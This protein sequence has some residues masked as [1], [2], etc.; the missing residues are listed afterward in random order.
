[1]KDV[2]SKRRRVEEFKTITLN[3]SC[4]AILLRRLPIKR[5]DPG[6]FKIAIEIGNQ[7]A[8]GAL[9]D[10]GASINL[11]PLSLYKK[12]KM[13]GLKPTTISMQLAD[14][15]IG[16]PDGIVE[17]VLVKVG[18]LI[19]PADFVIM[20]FDAD[21]AMPIILGRPFLATARTLIDVAEGELILRMGDE[22]V[23]FTMGK[24]FKHQ[25]EVENCFYLDVVQVN[26]K[27]PQDE[28][29]SDDDLEEAF[30]LLEMGRVDDALDSLKGS[31]SPPPELV[32]EFEDFGLARMMGDQLEKAFAEESSSLGTQVIATKEELK[33]RKRRRRR[34]KASPSNSYSLHY[35]NP[36]VISDILPCGTV[37]LR[38]VYNGRL[39]MVDRAEL[40]HYRVHKYVPKK[41]LV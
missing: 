19:F 31:T 36:V 33:K 40:K 26:E 1:M 35:F 6:T 30:K 20:D 3:E 12:L 29:F 27:P 18:H 8:G 38:D 24:K 13:A 34:N 14:R 22:K 9:C 32:M 7:L 17:V 10:L 23:V 5:K 21:D 2:L 11:M 28:L 25:G 37:K 41:T 39:I 16:Y 15:S 4:S